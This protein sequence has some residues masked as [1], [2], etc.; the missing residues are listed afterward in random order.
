MDTSVGPTDCGYWGL[1]PEPSDE[2]NTPQL[3]P[4][5]TSVHQWRIIL[6][7][8][9]IISCRLCV[10]AC[11][12]TPCNHLNASTCMPITLKHVCFDPIQLDFTKLKPASHG[13]GAPEPGYLSCVCVYCEGL[14][15]VCVLP[16]QR[17]PSTWSSEVAHH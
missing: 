6:L 10:C 9:I 7:E 3:Y 4:V 14:V 12:Y 13:A 2:R 1:N 5:I 11:L 16:S 15:S 17:K 8:Y